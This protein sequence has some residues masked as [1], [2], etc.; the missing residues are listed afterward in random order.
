MK[1]ESRSLSNDKRERGSYS[2]QNLE[3]GDE[4][5]RGRKQGGDRA[6]GRARPNLKNLARGWTNAIPRNKRNWRRSA[7]PLLSGLTTSR[8]KKHGRSGEQRN[9]VADRGLKKGDREKVNPQGKDA[10]A[11][12]IIDFPTETQV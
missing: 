2:L 6:S 11:R 12:S 8:E 4:T 1:G 7:N 3:V 5:I 9:T 10:P